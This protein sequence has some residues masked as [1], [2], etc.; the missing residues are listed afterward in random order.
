MASKLSTYMFHYFHKLRLCFP[1]HIIKYLLKYFF[2]LFMC[3][4]DN[5]CFKEVFMMQ[6]G[7]FNQSKILK[8]K[9][10]IFE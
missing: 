7:I 6:N 2:Q 9:H 5:G 3:M 10:V 4:C 1:R 8:P